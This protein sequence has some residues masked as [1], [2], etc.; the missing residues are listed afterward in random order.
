[1]GFSVGT[2]LGVRPPFKPQE[3]E[4][5]FFSIATNGSGERFDQP[6]VGGVWVQNPLHRANRKAQD[7]CLGLFSWRISF[8][9]IYV[10]WGLQATNPSQG[11]QG[12]GQQQPKTNACL[13]RERGRETSAS[14]MVPAP[15]PTPALKRVLNQKVSDT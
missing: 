11:G 2:M 13:P 6:A 12:I 4:K 5:T 3:N 15:F 8:S 10:N 9:F 7:E 1:M 14:E